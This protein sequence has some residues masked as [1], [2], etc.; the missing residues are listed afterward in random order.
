M[1][2]DATDA[3]CIVDEAQGCSDQRR[4]RRGRERESPKRRRIHRLTTRSTDAVRPR[5][6][7]PPA[8]SRLENSGMR[9]VQHSPLHASPVGPRPPMTIAAAVESLTDART[10]TAILVEGWSDQAALEA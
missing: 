4:S 3:C 1:G 9:A 2:I 5:P 6:S 7:A 8:W 10:H